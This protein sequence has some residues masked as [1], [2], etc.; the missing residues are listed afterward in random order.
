MKYCPTCKYEY[1]DHV[2]K[3]SDCGR[4]LVDQ[5]TFEEMKDQPQEDDSTGEV[6]QMGGFEW[7]RLTELDTTEQAEQV[8]EI[9]KQFTIPV[10]IKNVDHQALV[11]VP[12]VQYQTALSVIHRVFAMSAQA[13]GAA[14][15][16]DED[17]EAISETFA[18]PDDI[19][20]ENDGFGAK[21]LMVLGLVAVAALIYSF[22][23]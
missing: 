20:S 12:K 7:Q 1:E 22:L 11:Y 18:D 21:L 8:R 4:D 14:D 13:T 6:I 2:Q 23:S 5:A 10:E 9:M 19:E 3:C 15:T 16:L 17:F